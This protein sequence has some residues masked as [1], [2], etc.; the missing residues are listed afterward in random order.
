L[1]PSAIMNNSFAGSRN[2]RDAADGYAD[3]KAAVMACIGHAVLD[4]CVCSAAAQINR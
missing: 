3:F 4:A 1:F 2:A